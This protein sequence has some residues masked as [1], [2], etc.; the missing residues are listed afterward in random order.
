[1]TQAGTDSIGRRIA[2]YR[3]VMGIATAK[4]LAGRIG[5]ETLSASV[6]Q[7]IES[8]RKADLSVSQLLNISR[9]LGISPVLLLASID[10]PFD[11]LDLT[12]LS[13]YVAKMTGAELD[14]WISGTSNETVAGYSYL[15]IVQQIARRD[16]RQLMRWYEDWVIF[17]RDFEASKDEIT[18]EQQQA[19][20]ATHAAD[21]ERIGATYKRLTEF[22]DVSWAKGPWS[23]DG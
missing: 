6:I 16:L 5:S 14:A 17:E 19:E 12:G 11:P 23:A 13:P 21:T 1:M 15:A 9:G 10:R 4:D 8:G 22:V 20:L 3:R 18:P 7:N 2:K